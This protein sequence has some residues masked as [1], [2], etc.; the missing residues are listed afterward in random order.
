MTDLLRDPGKFWGEFVLPSVPRDDPAFPELHYWRGKIWPSANYLAY[1][2]LKHA[3]PPEQRMEFSRRNVRMFMD[4]WL[5]DGGCYENYT[6][7][8]KG[9][10]DPHYSWGALLCLIGLEEILDI[11]PDG[12]IRLNGGLEESIELQNIPYGGRI[13]S[14]K[15]GNKHATV[16]HQGEVIL[17]AMERPI[18]K[19]GLKSSSIRIRKIQ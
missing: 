10:S 19:Q 13:Y 17:E 6:P 11:E 9:S 14:V 18:F 4:N 8:G 3:L 1:L 5:A 2:G 15:V 16:R 7:D 12:R